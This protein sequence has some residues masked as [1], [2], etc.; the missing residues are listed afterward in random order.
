MDSITTLITAEEDDGESLFQESREVK[1][2]DIS[3]DDNEIAFTVKFVGR[4]EVP[5]PDGL[6]ILSDAADM[7][8]SPD[9]GTEEK[10]K[11]KK[12]KVSL[13][14]SVSGVD[15]LEHKTKFMLYTCPLSSISFCGVHQ[16]RANLF[17]F[18]SKHPAADMFHCYLFQSKKF[19]SRRE[20]S[21]RN[22]RDLQVE[23]L[24]HKNKVLQKE[25]TELKK[26]L[27]ALLGTGGG[28]WRSDRE[29]S[30][31][32]G[33]LASLRYRP[34]PFLQGL[35]EEGP[36]NGSSLVPERAPSCLS[37]RPRA[38]GGRGLK[39]EMTILWT[40]ATDRR[41]SRS[42]RMWSS[43]VATAS[44][45]RRVRA[46]AGSPSGQVNELVALIPYSDQ[47]LQPQRT[48]LYVVLSVVLCL[49]AS[50][51]VAFFMFPRSVLVEDDGIRTVTVRFDRN[52]SKVLINMTVLFPSALVDSVSCQVLYMKTVIGTQQLDNVI[53]I[54]PLSQR[55][56]NFT[57]SMEISGSLSYV[58]AFCTMASIK[59]HNIVVFMQTSVKTSYMVRTAQN[60][61]E[62]YRY[63][64]CGSNSTSRQQPLR[65]RLL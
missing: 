32:L 14:L 40:A 6:Q 30:I 60:T 45:A 19:A 7:L 2:S 48:K 4:V 1:M 57:V 52:N 12:S 24:R 38:G 64:D 31:C 61:L 11:K 27:A 22:D 49:L 26:R 50:S 39:R 37:R 9:K 34:R 23:A 20:E 56:M 47:R 13:F 62:A 55:Q 15:I 43:P 5:R 65:P 21:T 46:R 8:K 54:Q 35:P 16:T 59:V 42:F 25:N 41:I 44:R 3:E 33:S 29:K 17:G 58:Y 36:A 51:L 63:I 28:R 18:V 53:S 10:T